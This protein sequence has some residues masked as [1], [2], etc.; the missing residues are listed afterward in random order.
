LGD[1]RLGAIVGIVSVV[2]GLLALPTLALCRWADRDD[3]PFR[4]R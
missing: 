4:S 3:G 2:N 1:P